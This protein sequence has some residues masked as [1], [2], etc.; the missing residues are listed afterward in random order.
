MLVD[1]GDGRTENA[2]VTSL[3]TADPV[4]LP[5]R[6]TRLRTRIRNFGPANLA[7]L[8]VELYG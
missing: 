2:A 4:V 8:R 7:G 6:P 3:S 5:E 1:V